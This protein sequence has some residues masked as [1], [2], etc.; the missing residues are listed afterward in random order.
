MLGP[1]YF[2]R[3]LVATNY[4]WKMGQILVAFSDYPNFT[5][6]FLF[7]EKI[8]ISTSIVHF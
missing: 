1:S 4:G 5:V 8:Y 7:L 6:V 3:A 2:V